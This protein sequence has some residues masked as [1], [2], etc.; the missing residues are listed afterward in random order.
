[1]HVLHEGSLYHFY[2]GLWY[3][4][5]GDL[6]HD[7]PAHTKDRH[8]MVQTVSLL[9]TQVLDWGGGALQPDC[10]EE[11]VVCGTL[12]GEM[13]FKDSLVSIARVRYTVSQSNTACY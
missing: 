13:H 9:V 10:V 1:M 5:T 2:G 7:L 3:D 4:P 6:T 11:R 12:Y 8:K